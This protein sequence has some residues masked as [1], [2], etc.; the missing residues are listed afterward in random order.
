MPE[1]RFDQEQESA[2]ASPKGGAQPQPAAKADPAGGDEQSR[3]GDELEALCAELQEARDRVLRAQADLD[4]YQ[5]RTRR[6]VEERLRYATAPLLLDLLPVRDNLARAIEAAESA[7]DGAGLLE[8]VK[9]VS[10]QLLGVFER[11][12]CR[13]VEALGQPFDPTRHEAIASRPSTDKPAGIVTDVATVGFT[14]HDR[15]VR[16]AQVVVSTGPPAES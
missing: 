12:D 6:N 14:L 9:L 10:Q 13:P 11:H 7:G 4:N 2:Q 15:V 3:L 8:G 16:P 1:N 5:K